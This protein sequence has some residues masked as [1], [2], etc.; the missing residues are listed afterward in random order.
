MGAEHKE[1]QHLQ[2][3]LLADLPHGKEVAQGLGHLLV[4]NVQKSVVHPVAGKGLAVGRLRLGDL[5]L[6]M[7]EDQILAAGMDVDLL[8]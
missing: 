7:G 1:P 2:I 4:V 6:M 5:V 3:V 8:A